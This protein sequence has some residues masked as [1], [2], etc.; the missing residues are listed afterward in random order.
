MDSAFAVETKG[1]TKKFKDL[2]AVD[3]LNLSVRRGEIFGFLGPNGAGKTTTIR[4]ILGLMYPTSGTVSINGFDISD[5]TA[6][7]RRSLGFLPERVGFYSNLTGKQTMEFYCDM[8]GASREEVGPLLQRVGLHEFADKKVGTYSRGM[9]QLLGV[10]QTMIGS[11][12][13]LVLD[14]PAGGLDPRWIRMVK[15]SIREA[16][17]RGATVFFSSHILG[18]VEEICDRVAII[19]RGALVAE[20]TIKNLS[21]HLEMKP[22]LWL[23]LPK[24]DEDVINLAKGIEGVTEVHVTENWLMVECDHEIRVKVM[25]ILQTG[26]YQFMDIRTEEPSLEDMFLKVTGTAEGGGVR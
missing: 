21:K 8:K 4:M 16:K 1:L 5:K 13:L 9:I 14:E 18:E 20:D 10:A 7:F 12:D 19:N 3:N 24:V 22:R 11:P 6:D 23:Q 26:G 15:D 25:T 17:A 2:V